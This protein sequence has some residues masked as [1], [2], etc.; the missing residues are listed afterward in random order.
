M[1]YQNIDYLRKLISSK[2]T[3]IFVWFIIALIS[4]CIAVVF[5]MGLKACFNL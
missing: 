1:N 5:V 2:G 3:K 4:T